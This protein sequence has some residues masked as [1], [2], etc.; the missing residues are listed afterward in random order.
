ML[1][2][3]IKRK[4]QR[5]F[6]DSD[7]YI[8][9]NQQDWWD[10]INECQVLIVRKTGALTGTDTAA[11]NTY[12][13]NLPTDFIETKRV[14][15]NGVNLLPIMIEDLDQLQIDLTLNQDTPNFYFHWNNQ[16]NLYPDPQS[17]DSLSVVHYYTRM[18]ATIAADGSTPEVPVQYHEDIVRFCVMRA[19]ERN[20]NWNAVKI[21]SD[22]FDSTEGLRKEESKKRD[23]DFYVVRDDPAEFEIYGS[24]W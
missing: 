24:L 13:K 15:Y 10:W 16:L 14:T 21:S 7:S 11:A 17:T 9:A 19:H 5:L 22:F 8:I 20:E 6:G 23:D 4:A 1:V 12:P 18:P 2:S 3:D